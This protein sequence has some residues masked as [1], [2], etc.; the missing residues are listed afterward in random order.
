MLDGLV[1]AGGADLDPALYG[2][3]PHETTAGL[4]P[5]RDAG[6]LAAPAGAA[7]RDLPV[8]GIC[9][10]MQLWRCRGG[11]LIQHLPEVVGHD[12]PPARR[13]ASTASTSVRIDAGLAGRPRARR[14]RAR[15]VA[16]TTRASPTPAR[17][18]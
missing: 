6:E 9:R 11:A 10:G 1:L 16:T 13:R 17:S 12:G 18:R 4:R 7:G 2:E 5:D 14:A 3:E 15:D 8:L